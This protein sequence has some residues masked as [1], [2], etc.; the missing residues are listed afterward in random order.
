[1]QQPRWQQQQQ[2][3][4]AAT[5]LLQQLLLLLLLLAVVTP[6][7]LL[8]VMVV[9]PLLLALVPHKQQL[10]VPHTPAQQA[11]IA[12]KVRA[13]LAAQIRCCGVH[14]SWCSQ[15]SLIMRCTARP[16][17]SAGS[18]QRYALMLGCS[19]G[20][21]VPAHKIVCVCTVHLWPN[22]DD[23]MSRLMLDAAWLTAANLAPGGPAVSCDFMICLP[24]AAVF[25]YLP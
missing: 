16:R 4:R 13:S 15:R 10:E 12:G 20:C 18:R 8:V 21:A 11:S 24:A 17:C 3:L 22:P 19:H 6:P 25:A 23:N 14:C 9:G 1:M 7:E 2:T 5:A